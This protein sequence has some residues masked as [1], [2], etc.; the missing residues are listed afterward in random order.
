MQIEHVCQSCGE[1]MAVHEHSNYQ[2]VKECLAGMRALCDE[3]SLELA[4][5]PAAQEREARP[6]GGTWSTSLKRSRL[7][8]TS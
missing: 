2:Q 7:L 5:M 3:C 1:V 8:P 6:G 4:R